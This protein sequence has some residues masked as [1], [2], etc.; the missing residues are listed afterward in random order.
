MRYNAG[1]EF[2][3]TWDGPGAPD[4]VQDFSFGTALVTV[5]N[6]LKATSEVVPTSIDMML[7]V[8]CENVVVYEPKIL[9]RVLIDPNQRFR[10][11]GTPALAAVAEDEED[12]DV[13]TFEAEGPMDKGGDGGVMVDTPE[14]GGIAAPTPV[15]TTAAET[16][17][18]QNA[19]CKLD[20]GRKYEYCVADIHEPMRRHALIPK[21]W[22]TTK[23]LAAPGT[24]LT[25]TLAYI[26]VQ[27]IGRFTRLFSGYS[28]H[29]KFRIFVYGTTPGAVMYNAHPG[30]LNTKH[31]SGYMMVDRGYELSTWS[32]T[33]YV[34][35]RETATCSQPFEMMYQVSNN[36]SFIDISVP[37]NSHWNMLPT[38]ESEQY[39]SH[40]TTNGT[41]VLRLPPSYTDYEVF[42]ALGDDFRFE[43][44]CP[45]NG[46][47]TNLATQPSGT[48][49]TAGSDTEI[50]G[51]M[52]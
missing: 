40:T 27:P 42:Q 38:Q 1:T 13:V 23:L 8:R 28:G 29:L 34:Q 37:F 10:L 6:V 48:A 16:N 30:S 4:Q 47:S 19:P 17:I 45:R 39:T 20:L 14:T 35:N 15:D 2:L 32:G 51:F 9:P 46:I 11:T 52:P 7:F 31:N 43:L 33:T 21:F 24:A 3:R 36:C 50:G 22:N 25:Y 44:F 18:Q 26:P 5:A 49:P 41:I 12:I